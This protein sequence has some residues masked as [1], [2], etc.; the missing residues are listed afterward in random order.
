[1]DVL[2]AVLVSVGAYAFGSVDFAVLVSRARGVDIYSVGSGNPGASNVLR[3]MGRAPALAVLVGDFSKG[4]IAAGVGLAV[5]DVT[6]A[7]AAGFFAVLGHCFPVFHRFH[8]GKGMATTAG[9]MLVAFPVPTLILLAG[10]VILVAIT[11]VASIGS[12]AAMLMVVPLLILFDEPSGAIGWVA[13]TALLVITRHRA[14]ISRLVRRSETT[15]AGN[16]A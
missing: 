1:M 3:T 4:A 8:G 16:D 5:G 7:S 13:A 11:R 15:I 2:P 9:V 10:W 14:N 6:L 12:L